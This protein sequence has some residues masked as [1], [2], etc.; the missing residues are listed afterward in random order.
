M[1][2]FFQTCEAIGATTKKLQKTALLAEYLKL[3]AINEAAISALFLSGRPFPAWEETTL[4]IGGRWLWRIIAELSGKEESEL[5]AWYR[6]SGDLGTVA[7]DVLPPRSGQGSGVIE[8]ET[9]FRQIAAS[10]GPALKAAIARDLLARATPLEAKY[11]IKIMTGD[12]RI[13]L[14]D[15]LVEEAIAKAF[16]ASLADVQRANMLLGDIGETLR[17]AA[18]SRLHEAKM[19]M[20]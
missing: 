9:A 7:S 5:T 10:R 16:S 15:S 1:Q 20:L 4:Q 8:V 12:L 2:Q 18:Q 11:I 6:R 3:C 17:L 19:R 14:K 13:G